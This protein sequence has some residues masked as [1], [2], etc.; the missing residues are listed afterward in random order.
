VLRKIFPRKETERTPWIMPFAMY[1]A[2]LA[3]PETLQTISSTAI[4]TILVLKT[5]WRR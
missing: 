1:I 5:A 4:D 2:V 3:F